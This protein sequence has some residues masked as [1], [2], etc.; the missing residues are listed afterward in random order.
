MCA[1]GKL[2]RMVRSRYSSQK[3]IA[4]HNRLAT[5]VMKGLDVGKGSTLSVSQSPFLIE[6]TS[7]FV[8]RT[9]W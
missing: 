2:G 6:S 5:A 3:D 8:R 9:S 1:R 4:C 7:S